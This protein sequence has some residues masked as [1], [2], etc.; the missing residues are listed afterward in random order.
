L[1]AA[2]QS[3]ALGRPKQVRRYQWVSRWL[4]PLFQSDSSVLAGIR[5]PLLA[6]TLRA[7]WVKRLALEL[8]C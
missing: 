6:S 1:A 8:L 3:Y 2:L 5:D 4:T 7:P